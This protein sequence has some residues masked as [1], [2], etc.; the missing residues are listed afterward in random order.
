VLLVET[1]KDDA[2]RG[3]ATPR[4]IRRRIGSWSVTRMRN[5]RSHGLR[6]SEIGQAGA[7]RA[8]EAAAARR[9]VLRQDFVRSVTGQA[10]W[11]SCGNAAGLPQPCSAWYCA[12][13]GSGVSSKLGPDLGRRLLRKPS[14]RVQAAA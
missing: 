10:P 7:V 5:D 8:R 13:S 11:W 9:P 3:W 6:R 2:E 12:I 4:E 1:F 14:R